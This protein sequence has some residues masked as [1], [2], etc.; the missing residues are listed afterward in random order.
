MRYPKTA[1]RVYTT[2]SP[3][4]CFRINFGLTTP[5]ALLIIHLLRCGVPGYLKCNYQEMEC[6][7]NDTAETTVFWAVC[8]CLEAPKFDRMVPE[9]WHAILVWNFGLCHVALGGMMNL[10][11]QGISGCCNQLKL[12]VLVL[13]IVRIAYNEDSNVIMTVTRGA[14]QLRGSELFNI[15]SCFLGTDQWV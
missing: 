2:H 15:G 9:K 4:R 3:C 8:G 5:A 1:R 11:N 13:Q 12:L 14:S 6:R 7:G 10:G